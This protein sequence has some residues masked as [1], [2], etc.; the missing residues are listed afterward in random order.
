MLEIKDVSVY[1][2]TDGRKPRVAGPITLQVPNG[3]TC[4]VIGP[5]GCGKTSLLRVL[6][7]VNSSFTGS[8][9][10]DGT[11]LTPVLHKIAYIPQNSGFLRWKTIRNNCLLPV[12]VRKIPLD[13]EIYSRLEQITRQLDIDGILDRYPFQVSGGQ[14]QRAAVARSLIIKPDL[15][16][17]DEPFSSLDA[18]S[19][20]SAQNML[21]CVLGKFMSAV[22][23]VTHS[24]EEAV[25]LADRVIVLSSFPG[26]I[27][28]DITTL[29]REIGD[30]S[31]VR[32]SELASIVRQ[33]IKEER[34]GN[35]EKKV[36]SVC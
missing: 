5:S 2:E 18:L 13:G 19:R 16:L 4:A 30:R 34:E 32:Y 22:I 29:S 15:L 11:D 28:A 1:Y 8:V 12:K 24:I 21:R 10:L 3:Q 25:F 6:A 33:L 35:S 36:N 20:E 23:L 17:M 26:K 14:L 7:G 31:A 9:K 27:I